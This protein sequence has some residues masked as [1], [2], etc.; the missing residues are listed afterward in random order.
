LWRHLVF[1]ILLLFQ[2]KYRANQSPKLNITGCSLNS[3]FNSIVYFS[4]SEKLTTAPNMNKVFSSIQT[5]VGV[6]SRTMASYKNVTHCIFD[7]DGLLL[8]RYFFLLLFLIINKKPIK[9][10]LSYQWW[11]SEISESNN[12]EIIINFREMIFHIKIFIFNV[13]FRCVQQARIKYCWL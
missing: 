11:F 12:T 4:F 9:L 3:N 5:S 7:M 6:I 1:I 13:N 10:G 2:S 8:G